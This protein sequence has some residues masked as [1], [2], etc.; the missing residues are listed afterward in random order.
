MLAIQKDPS[1]WIL[2]REVHLEAWKK[3]MLF[4]TKKWMFWLKKERE[5]IVNWSCDDSTGLTSKYNHFQDVFAYFTIAYY[6][7]KSPVP[8]EQQ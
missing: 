7:N 6:I 1:I 3:I 5:K 8:T 4:K 2:L